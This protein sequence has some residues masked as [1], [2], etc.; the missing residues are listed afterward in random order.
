MVIIFK[1]KYALNFIGGISTSILYSTFQAWYVCQHSVY[2]FPAD[3]I[4]STFTLSTFFNGVLAIL[5]GIIAD[6]GADLLGFGPV[7]N[8]SLCN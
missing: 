3:W 1:L 6:L 4:S 7:S 2:G 8:N 5:A